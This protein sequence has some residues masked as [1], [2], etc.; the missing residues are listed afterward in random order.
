MMSPH[1]IE[2]I[3]GFHPATPVTGPQ[4]DEVRAKCREL[5]EFL[6]RSL[7]DSREKSL[8]LTKLQETMMFSNAAIAVHTPKD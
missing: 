3:F 6:N 8:A 4:H 7:P 2:G 1:E 5:A